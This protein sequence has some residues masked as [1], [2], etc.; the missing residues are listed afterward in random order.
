MSPAY[1]SALASLHNPDESL[2]S[3]RR[4]PCQRGREMQMC[5]EML[6]CVWHVPVVGSFF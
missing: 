5:S 6:L 4:K 3:L 1:T 2:L